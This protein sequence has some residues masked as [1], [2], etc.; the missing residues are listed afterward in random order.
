MLTHQWAST[1]M[2]T[3]TPVLTSQ[4]NHSWQVGRGSEFTWLLLIERGSPVPNLEERE[5]EWPR[6]KSDDRSRSNLVS[7]SACS[8]HQCYENWLSAGHVRSS[9]RVKRK[10][11]SS[12]TPWCQLR[13]ASTRM[14]SYSDTFRSGIIFFYLSSKM[15]HYFDLKANHA[16]GYNWTSCFLSWPRR[17]CSW[18]LSSVLLVLISCPG[19]GRASV[20]HFLYPRRRKSKAEG[21]KENI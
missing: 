4:V 17:S 9:Q 15:I 11:I 14:P 21:V 5:S 3:P 19:S 20:Q 2:T 13:E 7:P 8:P 1:N 10:V 16:I 12:N 18:G 6:I